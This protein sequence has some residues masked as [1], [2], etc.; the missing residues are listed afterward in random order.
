MAE[1]KNKYKY[2][3]AIDNREELDEVLEMLG[4]F[5]CDELSD[6]DIDEKDEEEILFGNYPKDFDEDTEDDL[7]FGMDDVEYFERQVENLEKVLARKNRQI[8]ELETT[9]DVLSKRLSLV[10]AYWQ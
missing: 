5:D 4:Y 6:D 3:F 9:V 7:P 2:V 8:D 10:K 1:K